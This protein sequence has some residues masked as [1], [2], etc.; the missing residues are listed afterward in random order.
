MIETKEIKMPPKQMLTVLFLQHGMPWTVIAFAGIIAFIITGAIA[1]YRFFLL[2]L[3]WIF[4]FVPLVMAFLYFYFGMKPLTAFN[5]IPH[6][7]IFSPGEIEVRIKEEPEEEKLEN[8][9]ENKYKDFK[10]SVTDFDNIKSGADYFL[11]IS[12]QK[13]WLWVPFVAL[14]SKDDFHN[15]SNWTLDQVR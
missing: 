13:G 7:I 8:S 10:T 14:E 3:I 11:I 9:E 4:L 5:A 1:D 6:K 12:R 15:I 2:A